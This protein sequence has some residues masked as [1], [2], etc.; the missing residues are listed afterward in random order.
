MFCTFDSICIFPHRKGFSLPVNLGWIL[1]LSCTI[2]LDQ[3]STVT[4]IDSVYVL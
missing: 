4:I 2:K 1:N 3:N